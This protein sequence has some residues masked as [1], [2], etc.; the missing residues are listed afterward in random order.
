MIDIKFLKTFLVFIISL[1][2]LFMGSVIFFTSINNRMDITTSI[3]MSSL[4][5]I[6]GFLGLFWKYD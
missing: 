6:P 4:L 2:A 3:F 5:I 1:I